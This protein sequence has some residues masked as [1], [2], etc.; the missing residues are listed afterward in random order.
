MAVME[1]IK[2]QLARIT[3]QLSV[4]TASQKMLAGALA[5]I[6][7]MTLLYSARFAGTAEMEP[8]LDQ[9]FS[10]QDIAKITAELDS[11]GNQYSVAGHQNSNPADRKWQVMAILGYEQMLP[12]STAQGFDQIVKQM[13]PWDSAALTEAKLNEFK[14][15]SLSQVIRRFPGVRDAA[16]MIDPNSQRRIGDSFSASAMVYITMK[17]VGAKPGKQLVEAAAAVVSGSHAGMTPSNVTVVVDGVPQRVLDPNSDMA[18]GGDESL[19]IIQAHERWLSQKIADQLAFIKDAKISVTVELNTESKTTHTQMYEKKNSFTLP[20]E[21]TS[22]SEESSTPGSTVSEPGA[23]PNTGMALAT[24]GAGGATSSTLEETVRNTAFPAVIETQVRTPAGKATVVGATVRVPQ[25]Y[26]AAIWMRKNP[27]GKQ[28]TDEILRT[29][30]EAELPKIREDVLKCTG[31]TDPNSVNVDTYSDAI[32]TLALASDQTATASSSSLPFGIGNYG[33]EIAIGLLAVVSL[34]MV[35]TMVKKG[36]PA[37]VAINLA[38]LEPPQPVQPDEIIAGEVGAGQQMLDGMELDDDSVR[39]QQMI[40][41][42]STMVKEN[43]DGAAS[44]VKRWLN[45]A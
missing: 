23:V 39:A 32:P 35:S 1:L 3:Q 44:L 17:Q 37:P 30:A 20:Q 18:L 12:S 41:Q 24:A 6:M 22:H 27:D 29:M 21:T 11:R 34:F 38:D 26:F 9:S 33:K 40:E 42:V 28:P 19:E 43:P 13:S 25:S 5:V 2:A 31:L 45:R 16:V 36:A 4:L 14:A 15:A 8:L 10:Q 7:V